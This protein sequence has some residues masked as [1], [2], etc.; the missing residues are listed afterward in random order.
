MA[1]EIRIAPAAERAV[2]KLSS[3]I[4][5]RRA[6]LVFPMILCLARPPMPSYT[7]SR[8]QVSISRLKRLK[9]VGRDPSKVEQSASSQP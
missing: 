6:G 8:V 9:R 4:Q 2:S 7:Q 1:Y 3:P 5:G